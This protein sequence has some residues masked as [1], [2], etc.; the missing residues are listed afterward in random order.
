MDVRARL[1]DLNVGEVPCCSDV[2]QIS[3]DEDLVPLLASPAVAFILLLQVPSFERLIEGDI[4]S[5]PVRNCS[6]GKWVGFLDARDMVSWP[7][8]AGPPHQ[9][10]SLFI[11]AQTTV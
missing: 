11:R 8:P 7:L 9:P 10:R 5:A 3:S 6:T 4:L 2:I 1:A